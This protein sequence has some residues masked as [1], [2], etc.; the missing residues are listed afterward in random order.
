MGPATFCLASFPGLKR[1]REEFEGEGGEAFPCTDVTSLGP[2]GG[3][4]KTDRDVASLR[5]ELQPRQDRGA[6]PPKEHAPTAEEGFAPAKNV[7]TSAMLR[8]EGV[9]GR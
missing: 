6:T 1:S 9:R 8:K 7:P 4:G 5:H 3:Y 2:Y